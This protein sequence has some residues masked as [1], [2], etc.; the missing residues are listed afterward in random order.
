MEG[1]FPKTRTTLSLNGEYLEAFRECFPALS[2][3]AFVDSQI[4]EAVRQKRRRE[5]LRCKCGVSAALSVWRKWGLICPS[6]KKQYATWIDLQ[7]EEHKEEMPPV[8]PE[9]EKKTEV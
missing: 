7:R 4:A 2:L 6:C 9:E 8:P 5:L 3:S 1:S